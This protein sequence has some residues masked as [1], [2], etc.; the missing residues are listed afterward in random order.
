MKTLKLK[1]NDRIGIRGL[2]NAKYAQGGLTL[3]TL[4]DASK[5][6][7]KV[8]I[9][10]TWGKKGKDGITKATGGDEAKALELKQ[11]T[12]VDPQG[13]QMAQ[14]IWDAKKDVVRDFELADDE[15]KLLKEIIKD[16]NEKKEIKLDDMWLAGVSEQL[17][18]E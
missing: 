2:L 4:K 12:S 5:L 1:F 7:D 18:E 3:D 14:L 10:T 16:K 8:S 17:D 6:L 9:E 15:A 11:V 13:R